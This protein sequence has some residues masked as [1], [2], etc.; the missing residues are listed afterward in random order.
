MINYSMICA[1][2]VGNLLPTACYYISVYRKTSQHIGTTKT[3][4]TFYY[5]IT[6]FRVYAN[7][8]L[9]KQFFTK[10]TA[11]VT[12][13]TPPNTQK[14]FMGRQFSGGFFISKFTPSFYK[15]F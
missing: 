6:A 3:R 8:L 15:V 13:V 7:V 14:S 4:D 12:I 9:A 11:L 10:L 2:R 5:Q 1:F